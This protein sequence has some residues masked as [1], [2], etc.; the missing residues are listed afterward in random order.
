MIK[1]KQMMESFWVSRFRRG[2]LIV[3]L[4]KITI[5]MVIAGVVFSHPRLP[6]TADDSYRV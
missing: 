4:L 6:H 5:A 1:L 2:I 3:L